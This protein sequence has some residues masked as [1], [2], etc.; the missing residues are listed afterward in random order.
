MKSNAFVLILDASKAF[1]RVNHCKLFREL[2]Q[3]EMSPL[4]LRLL[5]FICIHVR[6]IRVKW[7]SV[8]TESFTV[9]NVVKQGGVL[10]PVLFAVYTDK[11]NIK[12]T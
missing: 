5:L 6:Y 11:T 3:R 9:M 7:G 4:V 2:L 1:D 12:I 8:M 10:S